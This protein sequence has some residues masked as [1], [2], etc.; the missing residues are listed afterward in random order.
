VTAAVILAVGWGAAIIVYFASAPVEDDP[1]RVFHESK[2]YEDSVERVGGKAA[3]FGNE[4]AETIAG[5][6][7]GQTLAFTIAM[8]TVTVAFV[9]LYRHVSKHPPEGSLK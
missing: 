3:V 9:Y 2:R 8:L 4:V 6:F 1:L 5:L 7:R